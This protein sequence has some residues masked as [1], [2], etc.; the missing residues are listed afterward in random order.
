MAAKV[1]W[2][3]EAWWVIT[4]YEAKRKKHRVGTTATHKRQAE[5]IARKINAALA[6][7]T[8]APDSA[9]ESALPCDAELRRWHATYAATMKPSY[10]ASTLGLINKHLAPYFGSRD[11]RELREQDLLGFIGTKLDEGLALATVRNALAVVRRVFY[12]AQGRIERNPAARVGELIRRVG[13][14]LSTEVPEA[15]SWTRE[16]VVKLLALCD[17][18]EAAIAPLLRFLFAT[19]ARRGEA[20]GLQWDDVGF[21]AHAIRIR[22]S[23]TRGQMS[24]PKSGKGRVVAMAPA[25]ASALFDLFAARRVEA[26]HRGWP[27]VPPWVFCSEPERHWTSGT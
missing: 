6:L 20:L 4:H 14:R 24:S 9:R 17:E 13:R 10:E 2:M 27:E 21:S 25:L 12:L 22:R 16:E 26:L 7:G 5:E 19:G 3:R 18:H 23:I 1:Q 11:L 15:E 8:F